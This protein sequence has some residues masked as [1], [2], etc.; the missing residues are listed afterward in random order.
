V[1]TQIKTSDLKTSF[2]TELTDGICHAKSSEDVIADLKRIA[3]S[4]R[5]IL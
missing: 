5:T 2:A 4:Q 3:V 1:E